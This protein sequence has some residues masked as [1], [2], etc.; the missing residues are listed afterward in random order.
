MLK[1]LLFARLQFMPVA[2]CL[3]RDSEGGCARQTKSN[4]IQGNHLSEQ[5]QIEQK[6]TTSA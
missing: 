4:E 5:Q 3:Q 2:C 6:N 1:Y